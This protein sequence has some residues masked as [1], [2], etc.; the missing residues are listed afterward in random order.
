MNLQTRLNDFI[1]ARDVERETWTCH[2]E[3]RLT[4]SQQMA[5]NQR[6]RQNQGQG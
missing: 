1:S 2:L 3:G 5:Q 6:K 4:Q